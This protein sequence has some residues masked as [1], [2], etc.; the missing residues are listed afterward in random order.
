MTTAKRRKMSKDRREST[1][2]FR[3]S[4]NE[5]WRIREA[6]KS[7]GLDLSSYCRLAVLTRCRAGGAQDA[8]SSLNQTLMDLI[9]AEKK[10]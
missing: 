4:E 1:I 10:N 7:E 8:V 3:V 9:E 2:R 5:K 6:S